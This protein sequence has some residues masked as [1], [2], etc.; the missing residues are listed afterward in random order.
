MARKSVVQ[1]LLGRDLV[2]GNADRARLPALGNFTTRAGFVIECV[3]VLYIAGP[4]SGAGGEQQFVVFRDIL[5]QAPGP[6]E[7]QPGSGMQQQVGFESAAHTMPVFHIR[8]GPAGMHPIRRI[9]PQQQ[10]RTEQGDQRGR[11]E[12][13]QR[14][15]DERSDLL[16]RFAAAPLDPAVAG[17][18]EVGGI[19]FAN[20][21]I[22]QSRAVLDR[23]G[24]GFVVDHPE[25]QFE[26]AAL[27]RIAIIGQSHFLPFMLV[28]AHMK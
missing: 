4:A 28:F 21:V 12:P 23:A 2:S 6:F 24:P 8:P 22:A 26:L 17:V 27:A 18:P 19:D 10:A 13:V 7:I 20:A 25:R 5:Q 11:F 14:V 16:R 3:R 1:A 15:L 9:Y